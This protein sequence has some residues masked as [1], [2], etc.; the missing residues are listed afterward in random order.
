VT[1]RWPLVGSLVALLLGAGLAA[2]VLAFCG[3]GGGESGIVR[4]PTRTPVSRTVTVTRT[5]TPKGGTPVTTGT[6]G[7]TPSSLTPPAE[8]ATPSGGEPTEEAPDMTPPP[9]GTETPGPEPTL[10]PDE[11]PPAPSPT[12]PAGTSTPVPPTSTPQP[13]ATPTPPRVLPDLVVLDIRVSNDQLVV[14]LG[15]QG[16]ATVP[17]GQEI[18]FRLRGV[19]AEKVTL[20]QALTPGTSVSIVLE[21]QVIYRSEVVLAV[22]D[23]NNL[24]PEEDENN[25]SLAKPLAPDVALDLGV[26]GVYRSTDTNQLLVV[27][28]NTTSAPAIQV[29]VEVRVFP[30]GASVPS[31]IST[32]QLTIEPQGFETVQ[33]TG[34]VALSGVHMKVKVEM[35]DPPDANPAN[36]EWEGI[37]T[38]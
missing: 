28:R 14:V 22:V 33:V 5:P 24:I 30:Q 7:G 15:N 2:L 27:I 26:Q 8:T 12:R 32:Y 21:D 31:M 17:A 16:H 4:S 20:S 18:E 10:S 35:T 1:L 25:N 13:T 6:P 11:T 34:V 23:P 19:A 36:N 3:E 37:I 38:P 29:T 9:E